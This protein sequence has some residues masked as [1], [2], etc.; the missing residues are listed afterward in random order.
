MFTSVHRSHH[1]EPK[2]C[3]S[4]F[5]KCSFHSHKLQP[6]H[7]IQLGILAH[8]VLPMEMVLRNAKERK[9]N[10]QKCRSIFIPSQFSSILRVVLFW[11]TL[12]INFTAW[13]P[14]ILWT[15]SV[16]SVGIERSRQRAAVL[17]IYAGLNKTLRLGTTSTLIILRIINYPWQ[18]FHIQASRKRRYLPL[19]LEH[20]MLSDQKLGVNQ[21]VPGVRYSG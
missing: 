19:L 20:L 2:K 11:S 4:R 6:R 8:P 18:H 16:Y 17:S 15:N 5:H 12:G 10:R 7:D 13:S 9:R 14:I 1:L 3:T 21:L